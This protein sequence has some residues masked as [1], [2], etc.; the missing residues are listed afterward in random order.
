MA[1]QMLRVTEVAT[2]PAIQALTLSRRLNIPVAVRS[3][4]GEF[5]DHYNQ[6][7]FEPTEETLNS[8]IRTGFD[9]S[10]GLAITGR[11]VILSQVPLEHEQ[12]IN[13]PELRYSVH[14][15]VE[16]NNILDQDEPVFAAD[17]R[18]SM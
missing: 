12:T 17:F 4:S 9:L 13:V 5:S 1:G 15:V 7:N 11:G 8:K 6:G 2:N 3:Y 10:D 18:V 16:R 14:Q